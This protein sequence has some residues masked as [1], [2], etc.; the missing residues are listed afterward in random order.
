MVQALWKSVWQLL[1][2]LDIVPEE[3]GIPLLGI[4]LE[5]A[6]ACNKDRCSTVFIAA[7]FIIAR[8][9]KQPRC[10]SAEIQKM[11]IYTMEC[12]YS[13]IKHKDFVKFSGK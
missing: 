10:P 5:D 8:S 11:Y 9:W 1:R 13:A 6:P 2:I 4:Y 3:P 7:L 12:Y